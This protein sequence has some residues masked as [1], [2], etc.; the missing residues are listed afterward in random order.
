MFIFTHFCLKN[1][2]HQCVYNIVYLQNCYSNCVNIH[3][4]SSFVSNF[5][6]FSLTYAPL[7]LSS[8]RRRRRTDPTFTMISNINLH[9]P[10]T[11]QLSPIHHHNSF[12]HFLIQ[13]QNQ[14]KNN[15]KATQNQPNFHR[16]THPNPN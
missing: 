2:S 1:Y 11:T 16:K 4:Y 14:V 10:I 9:Q 6:F 3:D 13:T 15:S 7:M 5:F 12:Q 8:P